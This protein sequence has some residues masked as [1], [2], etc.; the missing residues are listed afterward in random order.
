MQGRPQGI[1]MW[2]TVQCTQQA[3]HEGR[4]FCDFPSGGRAGVGAGLSNLPDN[5]MHLRHTQ[6]FQSMIKWPTLCTVPGPKA[7][8]EVLLL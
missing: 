6:R 4:G 5:L 1:I 3:L 7:G 8:S 2:G